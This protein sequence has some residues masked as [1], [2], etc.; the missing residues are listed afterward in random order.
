MPLINLIR[1]DR[2]ALRREQKKSKAYMYGL[3][4]SIAI[5][6]AAYMT[7]FFQGQVLDGERAGLQSKIDKVEPILKE[8][9]GNERTYGVLSPR[10]TTLQDAVTSTQRW[11]RV[12]DHLSR[13]VPEGVWLTV[14]RCQQPSATEPV[15]LE[16]QGLAPNQEKVSE[17]IL[18]LQS[19]ADLESVQLKYTQGDQFGTKSM[20]RFEVSG[21]ITG[22]AKPKPVVNEEDKEGEEKKS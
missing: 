2:L 17:F 6:A 15:S 21:S 13:S 16:M 19:S 8:I 9:E 1:E 3:V 5:G 20:I 10:L 14:M 18:R 22:T 12:L 7:L 11:N 4:G